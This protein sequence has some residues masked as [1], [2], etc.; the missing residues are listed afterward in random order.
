MK[1][2]RCIAAGLG[3]LM[4]VN[5]YGYQEGDFQI[6][7][8]EGQEI[9]L[10]KGAKVSFEQEFRYWNNA[11]ELYYQHYDFGLV[12]SPNKFFDLGLFYRQ[13]YERRKAKGTFM[14]EEV[15]NI[16]ATVKFDWQG[17]D[18]ED[19]NR[20]EYRIYSYQD[21]NCRY[22]N[23]VTLKLPWKSTPW[24]IR[25]YFSDEIFVRIDD[26]AVF[27]QNRFS[28]GLGMEFL[29]NIKGEVY[30]MLKSDRGRVKWTD[31]NILGLK[32]KVAF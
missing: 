12:L 1:L 10:V 22:R 28:A 3:I 11:D 2:M 6:W 4:A 32:L 5:A 8:T 26:S 29:K 25:P 21:D 31:A 24:K 15:P 16:N 27:N 23:K 14:P 19:R 7:H 30:Y 18:I 17:F 13:I 20:F 9:A